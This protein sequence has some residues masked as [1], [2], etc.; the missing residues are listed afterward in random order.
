MLKLL[1]SIL[2]LMSFVVHAEDFVPDSYSVK[3]TKR[4]LSATKKE[5]TEKGTFHYLYPN[6]ARLESHVAVPTIIVVNPQTSWF[7]QAALKETKE[8]GLVTVEKAI[9]MPIMKVLDSMKKGLDNSA[10]FT[11]KNV[12]FNIILTSKPDFVEESHIKQIELKD[13]FL[14]SLK[15][16]KDVKILIT[17]DIDGRI[18]T[19]EFEQFNETKITKDYFIFKIPKNTKVVD[20]RGSP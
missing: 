7:Y 14:H 10:Y 12:G 8:L 16:M 19:Y 2:F 15:S 3:F 6:H 17:T 20:E 13:S 4:Y 5:I 9:P 18:T 1:V 11:R